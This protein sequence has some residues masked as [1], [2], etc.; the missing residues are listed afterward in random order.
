MLKVTK[1]RQLEDSKWATVL[2]DK[3]LHL[4]Q[5]LG[6][7]GQSKNYMVRVEWRRAR[8]GKGVMSFSAD[9]LSLIHI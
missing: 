4:E 3:Q 5:A 9:S 6:A 7:S 1:M 8:A 2:R